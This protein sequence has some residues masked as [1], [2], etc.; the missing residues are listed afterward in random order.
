M[1]NIRMSDNIKF[2]FAL[3]AAGF[4]SSCQSNDLKEYYGREGDLTMRPAFMGKMPQ[5]DDSYSQ[6]VR[7]GCNTALAVVAVGPMATQYDESYIDFDK[8]LSDSDYYKGKNLGYNYCG[9]FTDVD[10]I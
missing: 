2:L 6:G 10:P 8:T 4:L 3:C 7:D 9:Y 1:K 5:G